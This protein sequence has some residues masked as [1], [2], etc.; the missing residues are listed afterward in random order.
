MNKVIMKTENV[1]VSFGGLA[2]VKDVDFEVYEDEIVGLIGPNGAGNSTFLNVLTGLVDLSNG[3]LIFDDHDVSKKKTHEF[4]YMGI[5]RTFQTLR[6]LENS[7][8][9]ENVMLGYHK[10]S[11]KNMLQVIFRTKKFRNKEK[12]I[13]EKSYEKLKLVECED[14]A[15]KPVSKLTYFERRRVEIARALAVEPKILLLDEPAAGVN[16]TETMELMALLKKLKQS[17]KF[18]IVIIEHDMKLIMNMVD[19]VVVLDHGQKIADGLP[20]DVRQNKQVIE[21]YLGGGYHA[22]A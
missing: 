5:G 16:P 14:I 18:S 12:E 3:R 20:E 2:A 22:R 15:D 13:L 10:L 11:T 6:L 8:A 4:S 17:Q 19:R 9:I 21:S 7:T 1:T